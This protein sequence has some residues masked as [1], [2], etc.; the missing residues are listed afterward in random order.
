MV[1]FGMSID[2]FLEHSTGGGGSRGNFL[3]SW[4]KNNPPK[5]T[6]WLHTESPIAARWSHPWPKFVTRENKETG[7]KQL[8][9]FGGNWGCH[10]RELILSK[11]RFREPDGERQYPPEVC[12]LCKTIEVVRMAVLRG[13]ISWI[14]PIFQFK[15]DNPEN[16]LIITAGGLYNA[17]SNPKLTDGQKAELRRAGIRPRDAW[18]E[19]ANAKCQ[20]VFSIVNHERIGDGVQ[21]ATEPD[22][23][24]NA[25]KRAIKDQIEKISRIHGLEKGKL[26][27]NPLRN[28]YPFLWEY[29]EEENFDKKYRIVALDGMPVSDEIKALI[30]DA[31]P[32]D[33]KQHFRAGNVKALRLDMEKAALV[34]LPWDEIFGD[35]EKHAEEES[36]QVP[37]DEVVPTPAKRTPVVS[38]KPV[39]VEDPDQFPAS[40]NIVTPPP[41]V[42]AK[43]APAPAQGQSVFG[44]DHCDGDL[45]ES[46][47]ECPKC[48]SKFD[49]EGTIIERPCPGCGL[50]M[51]AQ[52]EGD[53]AICPECALIVDTKEWKE[54]LITKPVRLTRSQAAAQAAQAAATPAA[55]ARKSI[56]GA[57]SEDNLPW[58]RK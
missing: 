10:E 26:L 29:L 41:K 21:I 12:P 42:A 55:P 38:S 17:F 18:R 16:D 48:H 25:M 58:G 7:E 1:D 13:E 15:G 35:A 47:R 53:R 36:D 33:I 30:I 49:D 40:Y 32:P 20:Y 14:D 39:P 22:A 56:G 28:P 52:G 8:E 44:C 11:Q 6:V 51:P 37:A 3:K 5:I 23:L 9:V 54:A 43:P 27:G 46:D 50:M 45:Q 4:K 34:D 19:N 24:G 2:E 57:K 31:P